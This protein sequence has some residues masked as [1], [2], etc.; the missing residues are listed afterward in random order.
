MDRISFALAS[1]F[2]AVRDADDVDAGAVGRR[3]GRFSGEALSD[4]MTTRERGERRPSE[5]CDAVEKDCVDSRASGEATREN[6]RRRARPACARL[7]R[8]GLGTL[9]IILLFFWGACARPERG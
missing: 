9:S 6:A 1:V 2:A 7:R 8:N 5:R 4:D 3:P